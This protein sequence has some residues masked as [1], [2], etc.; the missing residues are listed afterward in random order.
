MKF[1]KAIIKAVREGNSDSFQDEVF[2]LSSRMT[3]DKT[4]ETMLNQILEKIN[5][6]TGN[7][8]IDDY[9]PL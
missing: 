6:K 1:L 9:N 7:M 3:L 4:K 5:S 2:K 8:L